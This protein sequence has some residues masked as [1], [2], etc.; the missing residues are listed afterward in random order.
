MFAYRDACLD[1]TKAV[2]KQGIIRRATSPL[3]GARLDVFGEVD[4]LAYVRCPDTGSLFLADVAPAELWSSLLKKAN[5]LRRS[6]RAFHSDIAESRVENVY[7]P[8]LEWIQSTLVLQQ[9]HRPSLIEVTTT[10][11]EFLPMLEDSGV[12]RHSAS[13]DE[14]DLTNGRTRPQAEVLLLPESLD[15]T[16]DPKGLLESAA[17]CLVPGG[18]IFVTGLV[19]SGFDMAVLGTRNVYLYPPDRT[20]C[21]SLR[22]LEM[23]LTQAGF[24]LLEVSTPGVLDVEIV[25][26]HVKQDEAIPLS[27]FER[28]LLAGN[29]RVHSAFQTF[30]QQNGMS[31]FARVV[32]RRKTA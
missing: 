18:F 14:T 3:T 23:L 20:N 10:P 9:I 1:A 25:R 13:I 15:R 19:S 16:H 28:E 8:K 30:L 7:R 29:D 31:S 22:G 11:S 24:E 21:F 12:F 2:L 17:A 26:A 5:D 27:G 32:A 6:P 4:G